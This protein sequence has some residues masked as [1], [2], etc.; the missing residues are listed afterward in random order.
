MAVAFKGK[1]VGGNPI[2]KP[3]VVADNNGTAGKIAK[4]LFQRPQSVNIKVICRLIE[5]Q[6]ICTTLQHPRQMH[7]CC[8]HHLKAG[9]QA[10]AGLHL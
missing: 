8:V 9:R 1:D 10:F 4:R 3:A 5:Q 2:K 7:L 6:Q